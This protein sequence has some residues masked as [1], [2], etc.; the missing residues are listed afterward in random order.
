MMKIHPA[1]F[2]DEAD[3]HGGHMA[4]SFPPESG[5]P[6]FTVPLNPNEDLLKTW[7]MYVIYPA[8]IERA[9]FSLNLY[10]KG[11]AYPVLR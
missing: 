6:S 3:P 11:S 1:V 7:K 5:C 9:V 2:P 4:V 10:W 8:Y